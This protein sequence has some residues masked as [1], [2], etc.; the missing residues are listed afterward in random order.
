M[1]RLILLKLMFAAALLMQTQSSKAQISNLV[2]P[3]FLVNSPA[4]I[5]G[6]KDMT[7]A[8]DGDPATTGDWGRAIDSFW[9][10]IPIDYIPTDTLGCNPITTSLT[11][12]FA[13]ISRGT[14]NFSEKAYY[15]QQAGAMACIIYNNIP[16]APVGMGAGINSG[17]VTIPVIM[18]SQPDG[19]AIKAQILNGQTV[20]GSLTNWGFGFQH[21]LAIVS[22]SMPLLHNCAI[23]KYEM[24]ADTPSAYRF[25]TGGFVANVGAANETG[26]KL[27]STLSFTPTGGSSSVLLTDSVTATGITTVDS[28]IDMFSPRSMKIPAITSKGTFNVNYN[29]TYTGTD[30]QLGNNFINFTSEVTDS[31]Y[32]KGRLKSNGE[33]N[34]TIAYRFASG[35]DDLWG[36]LYYVR[37]G[38]HQ[39]IKAQFT[40]AAPTGQALNGSSVNIYVFKWNDANQNG[41][42]GAGEMDFVGAGFKNFGTLDSNYDLFEAPLVTLQGQPIFLSSNSYYWIA[43]EVP[44]TLFLGCDGGSNFFS[45]SFAAKHAGP[46]A[47]EYWA[48]QFGG[49]YTAMQSA[50]GE[51]LQFPFTRNGATVD[52]DSVS[53]VNSKGLVPA[54]TLHTSK[55]ITVSVN[56]VP[57]PIYNVN[58]YPNPTDGMLNVQMDKKFTKV[59]ATVLDAVGKIVYK[60]EQSLVGGKFSLD[61]SKYA[62]GGYFLVM[63]SNDFITA[64]PF[65]VSK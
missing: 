44:G 18:I 22:G 5:I 23:P 52:I 15:A 47:L 4:A 58:L 12:K 34:A 56:G 17:S 65:N 36:P 50:T 31:V 21:D 14:C 11:G 43:A 57:D 10:N 32:S 26:L 48:P 41:L 6:I 63:R 13:L 1:K 46:V 42:L 2:D 33:P 54:V 38:G 19:V 55:N 40:V 60:Q 35:D 8:N 16:G 30:D 24:T 9:Y 20:R 39:A 51:L 45:R 64:K 7:V 28:V 59:T 27:K 49:T 53:F 25:Y 62:A 37:E 3:I 29:L 61:V